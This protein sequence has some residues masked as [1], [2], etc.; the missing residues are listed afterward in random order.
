M[1]VAGTRVPAGAGRWERVRAVLGG[2][3]LRTR[4]LVGLVVLAALG[5]AATDVV[6]YGELN[7][8][9]NNQVTNELEAASS[10]LRVD[11]ANPSP[12]SG[13]PFGAAIQVVSSS[14]TTACAVPSGF[15]LS[16]LPP[17]SR[18]TP[19][20]SYSARGSGTSTAAAGGYRVLAS[21]A[22]LSSGPGGFGFRVPV[23]ALVAIPL[24]PNQATLHRLLLA[25][26]AV[27]FA[28][29]VAL[30]VVGAAVVRLGMRPLGQMEAT[31][32][33][34][35][36][37][38]LSKRVEDDDERTEVG[39][40]G[41]SLNVMLGTI[42]RSFAEQQ[43]SEARLRRFLADASHELR[44]PVTSIRGY[45]ELFRRGA[46]ERPNDLALAMRRIED[47]AGRMGL[48]VEDLLLL[49]RLDQGRPLE[50]DRVDLA[51]IATDAAADAQVTEP[52]RPVTVEVEPDVAVWG[53]E[54]RLRQ[55]V[56]N[57]V[58]NALRHTP[59]GTPVTVG[60]AAAGPA[61][62][63]W[64]RDEGAGIPPEH[65]ARIFERFYRAD[66]SRTRNRG[67][68]GLGLSIVASIAA[69]HGGRAYLETA[70]G[71][72]ATFVVELPRLVDGAVPAGSGAG[73]VEPL[74]V[75]GVVEPPQEVA[76][77]DGDEDRDG[78]V[79]GADEGER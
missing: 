48:L 23:V 14:G 44:T 77:G 79:V 29:L 57:L 55:V 6:V 5:L 20:S 76:T 61:A 40:L 28:V 26:L 72:G 11:C 62:R 75:G 56:G 67:G 58:Q 7:A 52:D 63:L 22:T 70:V 39:R 24:E 10:N 25:E 65:A 64:V 60:V 41:R 4:L 13:L 51:A 45:A 36:A 30:G 49:A 54:Q 31:A 35:A 53:D 27:S 8:Y 1:A 12:V 59:A 46:A 37:G 33:A 9:L 71:E 42:E 19:G 68:T 34:I 66:A 16:G 38:D 15:R 32:A 50:Q 21:Q 43:A 73:A 3:S 47:E 18:L 2:G 78:G 74:E 17:L 69:S